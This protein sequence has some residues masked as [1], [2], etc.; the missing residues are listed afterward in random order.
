MPLTNH[1]KELL[2]DVITLDSQVYCLFNLDS[3]SYTVGR[4][5]EYKSK[6]LDQFDTWVKEPWTPREMRYPTSA[7]LTLILQTLMEKTMQCPDLYKG[8]YLKAHLKAL[9]E[10]RSYVINMESTQ[11]KKMRC[12]F[13][14]YTLTIRT[15]DNFSNYEQIIEKIQLDNEI[16]N[17]SVKKTST[18]KV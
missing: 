4:P 16:D 18:L 14:S 5:D 8:L 7:Y 9:E 12:I 13:D 11:D 1:Q 2:E 10:M 6:I 3:K 15:M 17:S